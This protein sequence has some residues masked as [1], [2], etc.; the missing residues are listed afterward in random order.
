MGETETVCIADS[1]VPVYDRGSVFVE[2]VDGSCLNLSTQDEHLSLFPLTWSTWTLHLQENE[3]EGC[4]NPAY[5]AYVP[6]CPGFLSGAMTVQRPQL[7]LN[8]F[9]VII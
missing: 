6:H 3:E 8:I 9:W 1:G 5:A 2:S 7:S 4:H